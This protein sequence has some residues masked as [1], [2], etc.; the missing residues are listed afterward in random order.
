MNH[1]I[2]R[3]AKPTDAEQLL[4]IYA[5][6]VEQTAVTFEY[7]VPTIEEFSE[8]IR[9]TL[10]KYPYLVAEIDGKIVGY[11]YA[12]AFHTRAAYGWCVETSIYVRM[13]ARENGIGGA[14]YQK[15]EEVLRRQGFLNLNACI[16]WNEQE[17]EYLTHASVSFHSRLG[18]RMV[19]SFTQCGYKFGR[20]YGMVWMEKL[21]GTHNAQT[22]APKTFD[23]VRTE[24]NLQDG[25]TS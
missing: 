9:Q 23:D 11:A 21:I 14:L 6:Y 8:R 2:L 19:G 4:S 22:N 18:Y 24:L 1:F 15:L 10:H 5:P 12:S 3:T 17:D 16:A 13:D 20:W 25:G 7:T